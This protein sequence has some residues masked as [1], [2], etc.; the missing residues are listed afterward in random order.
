MAQ[1]GRPLTLELKLGLRVIASITLPG[2]APIYQPRI[3][4]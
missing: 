2:K 1:E 4:H 3:L